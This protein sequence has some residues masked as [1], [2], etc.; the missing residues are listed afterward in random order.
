MGF[1]GKT[2]RK[3]HDICSFIIELRRTDNP[4]SH[5]CKCTMF[6]IG[7]IAWFSWLRALVVTV[8]M[9]VKRLLLNKLFQ[10]WRKSSKPD[11]QSSSCKSD[12]LVA[13]IKIDLIK[14]KKNPN[15]LSIPVNVIF[16]QIVLRKALF[17]ESWLYLAC[18]HIT[19]DR[20]S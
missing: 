10:P 8:N 13:I 18:D 9:L 14:E 3:R 7:W 15:N 6:K 5:Y 19:C 20:W 12:L 2:R 1:L 17:K 11:F 4:S 16:T